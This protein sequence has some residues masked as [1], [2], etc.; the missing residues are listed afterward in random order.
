MEDGDFTDRLRTR[1][2]G[3]GN[4]HLGTMSPSDLLTSAAAMNPIRFVAPIG[5]FRAVASNSPCFAPAVLFAL[6]LG[7]LDMLRRAFS[8]EPTSL[9]AG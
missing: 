5:R 3:H 7:G 6:T 2:F 1:T 4:P 8:S 9:P